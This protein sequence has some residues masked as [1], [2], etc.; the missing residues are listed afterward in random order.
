MLPFSLC[1]AHANISICSMRSINS[2]FAFD[3]RRTQSYSWG[4][5]GHLPRDFAGVKNRDFL[6][7]R[8]SGRCAKSA[9]F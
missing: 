2:I 5:C 3:D 8:A 9:P 1:N 7:G 6:G 4:S